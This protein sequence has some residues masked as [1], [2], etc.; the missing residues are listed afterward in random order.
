MDK[1][2]N[3]FNTICRLCLSQNSDSKMVSLIDN[4]SEDGLSCFGKSVSIVTNVLLQKDDKLPTMMCQKCAYLLKQTIYFKLKCE[5]TDKQLKRLVKKSVNSDSSDPNYKEIVCEYVMFNQYFPSEISTKRTKQ[6]SK[7]NRKLKTNNFKHKSL[8]QNSIEKSQLDNN[9]ADNVYDFDDFIDN[10]DNKNN[11]GDQQ[12]EYSKEINNI[13]DSIEILTKSD[14]TMPTTQRSKRKLKRE[15][16]FKSVRKMERNLM[17]KLCHKILANRMTYDHHMQ[18][19]NNCRLICEQCGKGFPILT[20]LHM[21]QV[22]RHGVGPYLECDHCQYKAPRKLDLIEHLRIHTGERPFTCDTCGLTFRRKAIWRNHL[23]CHMEKQVQCTYCPRKFY[24]HASMLAH[25]NNV[26]E[27]VYMYICSVC[28]V[29]YTKTETVKRHM[30]VKHGI[31]REKQGKIPR[32]ISGMNTTQF[33][34][35]AV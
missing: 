18:R 4:S 22:A 2:E 28:G 6:N 14:T 33:P 30:L 17:C 34:S 15:Q 12:D 7:P 10:E 32:I 1:Y 16:R 35:K 26:H 13:L 31:P 9:Y 8:H 21:H 27:R 20:E 24:R 19:H 11:F 3:M 25:C 29:T 5:S 23:I